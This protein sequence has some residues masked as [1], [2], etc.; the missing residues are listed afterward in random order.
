MRV[1]NSFW[2]MLVQDEVAAPE[3]VIASIRQAMLNVLDELSSP[4][5]RA[6]DDKI[7]HADGISALWNL[8]MDWMAAI[9]AEQGEDI[10]RNHLNKI[11]GMFR[12]Y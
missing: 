1:R 8:R 6:L 12:A 4:K 2:A 5:V 7:N 9:A 11:T 10:A 3:A